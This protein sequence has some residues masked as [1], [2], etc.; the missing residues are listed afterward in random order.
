L[1]YPLFALCT[2]YSA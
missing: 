1:N 2:S